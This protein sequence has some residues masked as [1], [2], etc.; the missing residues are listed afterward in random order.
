[1][2]RPKKYRCV[3]FMPNVTYF[4]PRGIPLRLLE[5]VSLAI[6][7]VEAIR[8]RDLES[9]QQEDC[10]ERMHISQPTFHRLIESA[11]RKVAQALIEGK[12]IRMEGGD[13]KM[14]MRKFEC[15]DCGNEWEVPF[16]AGRG[17]DIACPKCG[18]FNKYRIDA[19]PR[20]RGQG[21]GYC[22]I[23]GKAEGGEK[24]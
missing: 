11:H 15:R 9:L 23:P 1:M 8:L 5:E 18:S 2:S 21:A 24:T 6:E 19:G 16:G 14:A 13:F 7:E 20:G 10:A 17:I 22:P 12:A 3:E 4:K